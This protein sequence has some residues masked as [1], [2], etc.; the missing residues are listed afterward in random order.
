MLADRPDSAALDFES[1]LAELEQCA[2]E[3]FDPQVVVAFVEVARARAA[4]PLDATG[5]LAP[6]KL[7]ASRL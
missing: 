2:G 3:Q 5:P 1:A 7:A 6:R 4:N